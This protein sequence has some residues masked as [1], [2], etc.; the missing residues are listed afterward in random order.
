LPLESV[1]EQKWHGTVERI[2]NC[3]RA[4]IGRKIGDGEIKYMI[5]NQLTN[6]SFYDAGFSILIKVQQYLSFPDGHSTL[7]ARYTATISVREKFGTSGPIDMYISVSK[8]GGDYNV[9]HTHR[10]KQINTTLGCAT[11]ICKPKLVQLICHR[12]TLGSAAELR[13]SEQVQL[14]C[15]SINSL[16]EFYG[17]V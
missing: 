14:L 3:M 9:S 6:D 17:A 16:G 10:D 15:Q 1:A 5:D 13:K 2:L 8:C 4:P 12:F 7:R 11:E